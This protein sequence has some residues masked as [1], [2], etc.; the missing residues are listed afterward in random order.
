[1]LGKN[2]EGQLGIG[3]SDATIGDHSNEL[4]NELSYVSID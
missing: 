4:G 3:T 2:A 1:M